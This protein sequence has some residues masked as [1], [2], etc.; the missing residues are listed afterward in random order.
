MLSRYRSPPPDLKKRSGHFFF[1]QGYFAPGRTGCTT[2][3]CFSQG[4]LDVG[5]C[6]GP[7]LG[8]T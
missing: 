1:L 6:E 4:R 2:V 8:T 7:L 3:R 5:R